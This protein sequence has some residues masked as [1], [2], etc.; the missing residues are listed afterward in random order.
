[1]TSCMPSGVSRGSSDPGKSCFEKR[2]DLRRMNSNVRRRASTELRI[3]SSIKHPNILHVVSSSVSAD[4]V[5]LVHLDAPLDGIPLSDVIEAQRIAGQY[6]DEQIILGWVSHIGSALAYLHSLDILHG[7][8]CPSKLLVTPT[9]RSLK[10]CGFG[11]ALVLGDIYPTNTHRACAV[12]RYSA[13]EL[14]T[15][16][17][18]SRETDS[19]SLGCTFHELCT[20]RQTFGNV[21]TAETRAQILDGIYEA[22]PCIFSKSLRYSVDALLEVDPGRRALPDSVISVFAR[23]NTLDGKW[24]WSN[25]PISREHVVSESRPVLRIGF[26]V[27]LISIAW[28]LFAIGGSSILR[29][30]SVD[31]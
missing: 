4:G 31:T 27:P 28:G 15:G 18:I 19:W 30:Y 26:I 8:V 3:L 5:L 13:P 9:S 10:L 14:L 29:Y 6:F 20:L 16:G 7:G 21:S 22:V 23:P 24:G 25:G 2:V 17:A 11:N 1:M 12:N